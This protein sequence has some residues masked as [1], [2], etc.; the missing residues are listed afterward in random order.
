[1]T[2]PNHNDARELLIWVLNTLAVN[3]EDCTAT[4]AEWFDNPYAEGTAPDGVEF[5]CR[6][7]EADM[8]PWGSLSD[9]VDVALH[10]LQESGENAPVVAASL[11]ALIAGTVES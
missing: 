8:L 10:D 1:M 4:G 6:E 7:R 9:A 2:N 11:L 5:G 3:T